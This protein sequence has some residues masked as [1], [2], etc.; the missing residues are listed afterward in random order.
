MKK[1]AAI[2]KKIGLIVVMKFYRIIFLEDEHE[3]GFR[4]SALTDKQ[5]RLIAERGEYVNVGDFIAINPEKHT[6][7]FGSQK[8]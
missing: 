3:Q 1:E 7:P 8:S 6:D 2:R 4:V 5:Q